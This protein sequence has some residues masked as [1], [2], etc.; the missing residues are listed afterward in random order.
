MLLIYIQLILNVTSIII[1]F[2]FLHLSSSGNLYY[3]T[4]LFKFQICIA[5]MQYTVQRF[6]Y[7]SKTVFNQQ[8]NRR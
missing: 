3:Y 6:I 1:R 7:N 2:Y 8:T 5:A 4:E